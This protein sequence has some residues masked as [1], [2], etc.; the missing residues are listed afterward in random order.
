[1]FCDGCTRLVELPCMAHLISLIILDLTDC[2][3]SKFPEISNSLNLQQL[4]LSGTHIEEVPSFIGS[5]KKLR[6]L[7]MSGTKVQNIPSSIRELDALERFFLKDCP[8]IIQLNLNMEEDELP[9]SIPRL[10]RLWESN[11]TSLKSLSGLPP[12][13]GEIVWKAIGNVEKCDVHVFYVDVETFTVTNG[14]STIFR[15]DEGNRSNSHKTIS[16]NSL[17][18]QIVHSLG[19]LM[20]EEDVNGGK[21]HGEIPATTISR[22]NFKRLF[23]YYDEGDHEPVKR[24]KLS[25][26]PKKK[27][28]FGQ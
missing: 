25:H 1:M 12:W 4:D 24:V 19:Q 13:L 3:I 7:T 22:L 14:S 9:S 26:P 2:P 20:I 27:K 5:L 21:G 17:V 23:S 15:F 28:S 8:T 10:R 16:P 6:Y 18:S 11:C